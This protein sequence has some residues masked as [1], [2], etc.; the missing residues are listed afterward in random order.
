VR[1]V[2]SILGENLAGIYLHGSLAMGCHNPDRSDIDLIVTA[3]QGLA[4]ETRRLLAGVLLNLS[5]DPCPLEV[6]IL[7]E[8]DLAAWRH[9]FPYDFHFSEFWRERF[10]AHLAQ[11]DWD[12]FREDPG[13]VDPDLAAHLTILRFRGLALHGPSIETTFPAV[14][15]ADYLDAI[16]YD[17]APA[18]D[19]IA[20]NPVY[21]VLNMLRVHWYLQQGRISSKEEAGVWGLDTLPDA[22]LRTV[23]A[24]ALS[25]YR[26]EAD[27]P[28]FDAGALERFARTVDEAVQPLLQGT[29]PQE[30][31]PRALVCLRCGHPLRFVGGRQFISGD[32]VQMFTCPECGKVE[33]F[34]P[35]TAGEVR[36]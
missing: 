32:G 24:T 18:R 1:D 9:P 8:G 10:Q 5:G 33:F 23:C 12:L 21:G 31:A 25:Q 20:G 2:R 19:G 4:P 17:Y 15:P 26:G 28:A 34:L 13:R 7:L 35:E 27:A 14:L 36:G 29:A 6:H 30:S 3:R 22:E 11:R 16:L